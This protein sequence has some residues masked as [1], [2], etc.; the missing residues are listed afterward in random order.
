MIIAFQIVLLLITI[1]TV[2]GIIGEDKGSQLR[3]HLTAICLVSIVSLLVALK[4]L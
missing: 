3:P 2:I 4:Y 1:L